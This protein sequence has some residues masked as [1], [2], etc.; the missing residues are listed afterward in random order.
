MTTDT[1]AIETP[2]EGPP[3][4]SAQE[5]FQNHEERLAAVEQ[6]IF[7]VGQSNPVLRDAAGLPRHPHAFTKDEMSGAVFDPHAGT[8][9]SLMAENAKMR[10]VLDRILER[11]PQLPPGSEPAT[12]PA[13]QSPW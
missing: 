8:I 7:L 5:A 9:D 12:P 3:L 2:K 11:L 6:M 13:Q 1:A 10:E 4:R